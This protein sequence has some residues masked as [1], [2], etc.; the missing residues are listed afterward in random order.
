MELEESGGTGELDDPVTVP[1]VEEESIWER[2]DGGELIFH[3]SPSSL[4]LSLVYAF[5]SLISPLW[6]F[7]SLERYKRKGYICLY[8]PPPA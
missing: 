7:W 4:Y 8:E 2:S 1:E 3:L 5:L 6:S